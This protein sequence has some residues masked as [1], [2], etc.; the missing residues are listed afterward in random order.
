[1]TFQRILLTGCSSGF[2]HDAALRLAR[3]GHTVLAS[4]RHTTTTN[5]AVADAL[6]ATATSEGLALAVIDI[7]LSDPRSIT[8]A[9]SAVL[10]TGPL[11]VVVNNAGLGG[12]GW[13]EAFDDAQI[14]SMFDVNFFGVLT[15]NRAVLPAMRARGSGLLLHVTSILAHLPARFMSGY[16][17]TKAALE[18]YAES[19]HLEVA[20]LGVQS[21]IVQPGFFATDF[22]QNMFF[23]DDRA[24][25]ATYGEAASAPGLMLEGF[26]AL[27]SQMPPVSA[28]TDAMVR[29]IELA[30]AD[31]PL[32]TLVSGEPHGALVARI[33]EVQAAA[34][35]ELQL[36]MAPPAP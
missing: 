14:R 10:A 29:L 3:R 24:R 26:G 2:G 23:P 27:L 35:R 28:L 16:N 15:L 22:G 34:T 32:R 25:L 6:R 33:N 4:M 11:D 5:A 17:A 30:P 13:S 9:V 18:S 7:D 31:R 36:A 19:L 1:M 21:L 12:F 20:P 8:H